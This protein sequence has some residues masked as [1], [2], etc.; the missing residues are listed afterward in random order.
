MFV[1]LVGSTAMGSRLDP[2][3]FY[4]TMAAYHGCVARIVEHLGGFTARYSGDG[5]LAYFGFPRAMEDDAERAVSAGLAVAE[6]VNLLETVAGPTG[7]LSARIGIATGPV[8]VSELINADQ[9]VDPAV[10]G[11]ALNLAARLQTVAERDSVVIADTTHRLIG[12]L[13][14]CRDL[15]TVSMKGFEPGVRAWAVVGQE[16]VDS[17]FVALRSSQLP[18]IGREEELAMLAQRWRLASSGEGQVVLVLGEPGIGKSR[19]IADFEA[20]LRG[21]PHVRIR[22]S[23]SPQG[24][25][26]PL[27]PVIRQL[28][29]A[30]EFHIDDTPAVKREKLGTLLTR[31]GCSEL[32]VALIADLLAVPETAVPLPSDVTPRRKKEL[33]FDAIIRHLA[34]LAQRTPALVIVEDMHW[35]DPTTCDLLDLQIDSTQEAAILLVVS[36]RPEYQPNWAFHPHVTTRILGR[37]YPRQTAVLVCEVA[38]TANEQLAPDITERIVSRSDG[39]PLFAEELTKTVIE[40]GHLRTAQASSEHPSADALP[41]SLR[42]SLMARLDR[43]DAGKE[44]AQIG[45]VIGRSFSFEVLRRLAGIEVQLLEN[46][47]DNLVQTGLATVRGELPDAIYSFKHTLVQDAAYASLTRERRRAL[48]LRLAELLERTAGIADIEPQLLALHFGEG[49]SAERSIRYYLR[50][51]ERPTG[52]FALVERVNHLRK[53][54]QQVDGLAQSDTKNRLELDLRVALGLALIDH[55]G[56]GSEEVRDT[57]ERARDLCLVLKDRR[58]LLIVFD[59]LVSNHHFAHS[60]PDKML[61]YA[62]ELHTIGQ[63]TGDELASLWALRMRSAAQLLRGQ[64]EEARNGMQTVLSLWDVHW[65]GSQ[66]E[67]LVRDPKVSAYMNLGICLTVLGYPRSASDVAREGIRHA[68]SLGQPISVMSALRRA[69]V[70]SMIQRD[71]AAVLDFSSRLLALNEDRG[72]FIY[73]LEGQAC[74]AWATMRNAPN[75]TML[76]GALTCLDQLDVASHWVMLPFLMCSIAEIVGDE[77]DHRGAA[78]LLERAMNL[79]DRSGERWC[80]AEIIRLRSLF[81]RDPVE[82][83]DLFESSLAV[84]RQQ[85]A[86]FW[87]LRTST[88]IARRWSQQGMQPEAQKLLEPIYAWFSEGLELADLAAARTILAQGASFEC[89]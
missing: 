13:F 1:D 72:V 22:I 27:S 18:L 85:G 52:R 37:L 47:L 68:E 58:Q 80:E 35:A 61:G 76:A 39:I 89:D 4:S 59:A 8:V 71:T 46:G 41:T 10:I 54:L 6:N 20:R 83:A 17:R 15:G 7:T 24:Q 9:S 65:V 43:L 82:T 31:D 3:D 38:K 16:V 64:F 34:G 84:A 33:T 25:D 53:G 50:A 60:E 29:R 51:A 21:K 77:G 75:P 49:G 28:E 26:T 81:A 44:I 2:E 63:Q 48:H 12:Q 55:A 45:A 70:Q 73:G 69:C 88:T 74:Q 57:L 56:S 36:A 14:T 19:I 79:V 32:D 86:K 66:D 78:A 30:A 67:R 11:N 40:A 23:C 62:A 42:S 87:E 5:V